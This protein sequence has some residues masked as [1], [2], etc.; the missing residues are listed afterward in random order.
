MRLWGLV[1]YYYLLRY[2]ASNRYNRMEI[3]NAR[4]LNKVTLGK[5]KRFPQVCMDFK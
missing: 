4:L 5:P 2:A 1:N 3:D